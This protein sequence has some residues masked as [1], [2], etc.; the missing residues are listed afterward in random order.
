MTWTALVLAGSRGPA[1]PVAVAANVPHKALAPVGGRPMIDHV[2]AALAASPAIDR[3]AVSGPPDLPLPPEVSILPSQATPASSVLSAIDELG[4]PL[5]VTT[6]DNPLLRASTVAA[7]L[8][9]VRTT[10]ADAVAAVAPREIVELAGNPGRRTYLKF[11]GEA[12]SG[13]NLFALSGPAGRYA[14]A[15]WRKLETDRKRPLRMALSIGPATVIRYLAG[16][17]TLDGAAGAIGE[18]AGCTTGIVRLDDRYAAHD[19]DKPED[20]AF[21][22][23]VI[24]HRDNA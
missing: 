20:L 21:A 18:R 13:C 1:D 24:R 7:F 4:T 12:V 15:F 10:G 14:A 9:G 5:L 11:R 23:T 6:A 8:D 3:I 17:L 22:E 16:S 2:I 19:V